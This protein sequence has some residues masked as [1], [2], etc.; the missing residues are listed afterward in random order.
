MN[1]AQRFDMLLSHHIELLWLGYIVSTK[2]PKERDE[3]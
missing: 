1:G 3:K 2:H